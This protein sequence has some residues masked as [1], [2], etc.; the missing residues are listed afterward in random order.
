MLPE[1]SSPAVESGYQQLFEV[2]EMAGAVITGGE[3]QYWASL[4]Q[5]E[6]SEV[7]DRHDLEELADDLVAKLTGFLPEAQDESGKVADEGPAVVTISEGKKALAAGGENL[8]VQREGQFGN[9][10]K[11]KLLLQPLDQEG[12]EVIHILLIVSGEEP[13][14]LAEL[15]SRIPALL[16]SGMVGSTLSF[17]LAGEID[18]NMKPDEMEELA[19]SLVRGIGGT[20][21]QGIRDGKM[22]SVTGYCPELGSYFQAGKERLNLNIALR[23]NDLTGNI[24]IWAGTPLISGWY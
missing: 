23:E 18:E 11:M 24:L 12:R 3:L 16:D 13:H 2:M 14:S 20:E 4:Q 9:G 6:S 5:K 17:S 8:P 15:A 1:T 19:H 10:A 7:S 21:G 22:V